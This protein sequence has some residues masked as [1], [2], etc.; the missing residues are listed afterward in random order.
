MKPTM[1]RKMC[2]VVP[3]IMTIVPAQMAQVDV[4]VIP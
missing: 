3:L 4:L 2:H 1:L